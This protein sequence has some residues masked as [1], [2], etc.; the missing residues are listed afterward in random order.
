MWQLTDRGRELGRVDPDEVVRQ[1][2][3]GIDID[4]ISPELP[5]Y[6]VEELTKLHQSVDET[7]APRVRRQA[8]CLLSPLSGEVWT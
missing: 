2:S 7:A 6:L 5:D 3:A 8:R 4:V 1:V